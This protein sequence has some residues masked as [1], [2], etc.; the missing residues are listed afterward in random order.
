MK[1]P[2][3]LRRKLPIGP[4]N[5]T[6]SILQKHKIN[7][8]CQEANCPNLFECYSKK[9]ATFIA[10][11]KKCTRSCAFCNIDFDKNPPLP[12]ID[13][14]IN[15]A[16]AAKSLNLLHIVITMVARDDLEDKGANH[17]AKIVSEVKKLN[18]Q[19]SIEILTSDFSNRFDLID[20]VL[21][22]RV[23]VFNHN[24]ETVKRLSPK[25]RHIATY[26]NSFKVL[27]YVKE[28]KKAMFVKSG[29][30]VG[31]GERKEEV[32]E[33]LKDLKKS[34]VDIVTI[35]QYLSPSKNKYPIKDFITLDIYK[36]YEDFAKSVGI[37]NIYAGPYV[38]SSYNAQIIKN[39]ASSLLV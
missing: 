25:I 3:F 20:I 22:Q 16:K 11:G 34:D 31:L 9:T 26:E 17:I 29:F 39:Q 14:P 33:T 19:S 15:I 10:L 28:S 24:I 8:V 4:L 1:F 37:K 27:K 38:R 13:E 6:A 2:K 30:M 23:D 21:N 36:E 7:T 5:K 12:D 35:G 18:P 32:F